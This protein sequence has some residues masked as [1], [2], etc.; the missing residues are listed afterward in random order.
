M[1]KLDVKKQG[2]KAYDYFE[3]DKHNCAQAV[4]LSFSALYGVD[5]TL[6]L[7]LTSSLGGGLCH[8][9]TCGAL[10]GG[11]LVM[12]HERPFL[13]PAN[14]DSKVLNKEASKELTLAFNQELGSIYCRQLKDEGPDNLNKHKSSCAEL[15]R[16]GAE[17][18]AS[19]LN[20]MHGYQS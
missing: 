13:N 14:Q 16:K 19:R 1:E 10:V 2:Q 4:Y 6:A 20:K 17:L 3:T 15:C 7:E 8:G 5:N 9:D 18:V 12:G 11:L